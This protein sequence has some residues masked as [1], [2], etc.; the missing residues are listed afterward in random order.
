MTS[1]IATYEIRTTDSRTTYPGCE[2][3]DATFGT[4]EAAEAAIASLVETGEWSESDLCIKEVV[5]PAG[6]EVARLAVKIDGYRACYAQ[7]S[8]GQG[9]VV[10]TGEGHGHMS[11][12]DLAGEAVAEARRAGIVESWGGEDALR[13]MLRIGTWRAA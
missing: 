3:R 12:D 5:A 4:R 10:L 6:D 11:D 13:S 7:S 2:R 9:E 1:T 8:D